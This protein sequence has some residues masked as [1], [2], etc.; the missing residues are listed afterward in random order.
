M[1]MQFMKIIVIRM[2]IIA[3]EP[4]GKVSF[5]TWNNKCG[6]YLRI[7]D[8]YLL[9]VRTL[10]NNV[11]T[12]CHHQSTKESPSQSVVISW[13]VAAAATYLLLPNY[14]TCSSSLPWALLQLTSQ[15]VTRDWTD[16]PQPQW[17]VKLSDHSGVN[18]TKVK[19]IPQWSYDNLQ[20]KMRQHTNQSFTQV[21]GLCR[22]VVMILFVPTI[23]MTVTI[24]NQMLFQW[25]N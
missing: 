5:Q 15:P 7:C 6:G 9:P 13:R 1:N 21:L 24:N 20:H 2:R 23:A 14:Q 19:C 25:V 12:A 8:I 16:W 4:H 3:P 17:L 18:I 22:V 11:N 10:H